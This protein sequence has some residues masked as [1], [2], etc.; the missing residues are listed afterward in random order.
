MNNKII[1]VISTLTALFFLSS[2]FEDDTAFGKPEAGSKITGGS[3]S[4]KKSAS[5]KPLNAVGVIDSKGRC[6]IAKCM[7]R[8]GDCDKN[9]SNG[10]ETNLNTSEN[11]GKCGNSCEGGKYNDWECKSG[12]CYSKERLQELQKFNC[13]RECDRNLQ[14]AYKLC[15]ASHGGEECRRN[16]RNNQHC[17]CG[18]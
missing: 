15:E 9:P 3:K 7:A 10:C 13:M 17:N 16:A 6:V 5:C 1:V 18:R 2:V 8:Y 11:C 4:S 14:Q 12:K